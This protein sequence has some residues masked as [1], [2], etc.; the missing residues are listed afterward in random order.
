MLVLGQG[1]RRSQAKGGDNETAGF[2]DAERLG[3]LQI[4]DQDM[5]QMKEAARGSDGLYADKS[6]GD[7]G[8]LSV[9]TA[10]HP[11]WIFEPG[12]VAPRPDVAGRILARE[13]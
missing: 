2:G 1:R 12:R 7:G 6:M 11:R 4:N 13:L 10:P 5:G 8:N 3:C 9:K